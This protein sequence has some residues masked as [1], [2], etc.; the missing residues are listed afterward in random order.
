MRERERED[1]KSEAAAATAVARKQL[2]LLS[3]SRS[4]PVFLRLSSPRLSFRIRS[5]SAR[6]LKG[7]CSSAPL[8]G[9]R[10]CLRSRCSSSEGARATHAGS[11]GTSTGTGTGT[12]TQTLVTWNRLPDS[13]FELTGHLHTPACAPCLRQ[14]GIR[15]KLLG[16]LHLWHASPFVLSSSRASR[17]HTP[18]R[19]GQ[20]GV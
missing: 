15:R 4:S 6:A 8:Q 2:H 5:I 18:S 14:Q 17:A 13:P 9:R 12:R 1:G 16:N 20:E 7:R 10:R 19:L 11:S 3:L